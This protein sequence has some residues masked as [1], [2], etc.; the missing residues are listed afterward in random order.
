MNC[1]AL[2]LVQFEVAG[3]SIIPGCTAPAQQCE[4]KKSGS[5][6]ERSGGKKFLS[7]LPRFCSSEL[8]DL[9]D[10]SNRGIFSGMRRQANDYSAWTAQAGML[11]FA[12]FTM[13]P[14]KT[15]AM[16][17]SRRGCDRSFRICRSMYF[18][19]RFVIVLSLLRLNDA[20]PRLDRDGAPSLRFH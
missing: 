3:C 20:A 12:R 14:M 1:Q 8:H 19:I 10:A 5:Y 13:L 4:V 11:L 18:S 15:M 17:S 16:R 9:E 6:E 7:A 2:S